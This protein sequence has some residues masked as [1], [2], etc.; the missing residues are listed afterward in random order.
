MTDEELAKKFLAASE[1][2]AVC[3]VN[4]NTIDDLINEYFGTPKQNYECVAYE[5]WGN[6]SD[7]SFDVC[8]GESDEFDQ[9]DIQDAKNGKWKHYCLRTYL[10]HLCNQDIIPECE[11]IVSVRW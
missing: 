7:H 1:F 10:N 11:L 6:D 3:K 5:E 2:K 9:E 8:K 4:Y